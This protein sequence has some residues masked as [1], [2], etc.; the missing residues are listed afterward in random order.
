MPFDETLNKRL[1]S[2]VVDFTDVVALAHPD[3]V[4]FKVASVDSRHGIKML[5]KPV[6]ESPVHLMKA[7]SL[8]PCPPH[9][10]LRYLDTEIRAMWDENIAS[11][12]VIRKIE[13]EQ[14]APTAAAATSSSSSCGAEMVGSGKVATLTIL[15]HMEFRSPL[16]QLFRNRDFEIIVHEHM[17][18][19]SGVCLLKAFSTPR[20]YLKPV[21]TKGD[22][23]S[24]V[25][26]A[27]SRAS[28]AMA[29]SLGSWLG[30]GSSK[31]QGN[32]NA[33][34]AIGG[35][36]GDLSTEAVVR[37]SIIMSGFVVVPLVELEDGTI[38]EDRRGMAELEEKISGRGGARAED[39]RSVGCLPAAFQLLMGQRQKNRLQANL[40]PLEYITLPAIG[41]RR[42]GGEPPQMKQYRVVGCKVIYIA[43]VQPMGRIPTMLVNLVVGKQTSGLKLLQRFIAR[44]PLTVLPTSKDRSPGAMGGPTSVSKL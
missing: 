28:Q 23:G 10:F 19:H 41:E 35:D 3:A 7:E 29:A 13:V 26:G 2:Q 36:V 25:A 14:A 42:K 39:V 22:E 17:D 8:M 27:T 18:A 44:H 16:P 20:G 9:E 15:K 34:S 43:L 30:M 6:E 37:G 32:P 24:G 21:V 1:V 5:T 38:V 31:P 33:D 12:Q 11:S 4:G 40:T